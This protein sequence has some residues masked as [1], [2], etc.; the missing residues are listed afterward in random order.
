MSHTPTP[1]ETACPS[2]AVRLQSLCDPGSLPQAVATH[3]AQCPSCQRA[4]ERWAPAL[5][6]LH[7]AEA[8]TPSV[9]LTQRILADLQAQSPKHHTGIA[10]RFIRYYAAAA[11]L[12][13]ACLGVGLHYHSQPTPNAPAT[14]SPQL[15]WLDQ[16]QATD[17]SWHPQAFG[18]KAIY[19][20]ALTGLTLMG[21]ST[22]TPA[23]SH[24]PAREDTL[25]RAT[26][27][28]IDQQLPNGRIGQGTGDA[29]MYNHTMATLGLIQIADQLPPDIQHHARRAATKA[30]AFTQSQQLAHGGWGYFQQPE[31]GANSGVTSWAIQTLIEAD[32]HGYDIATHTI[33]RGAR[34]LDARLRPTG[35]FSY[36]D[37]AETDQP[38]TALTAMGAL[39]LLRSGL[40]LAP[41]RRSQLHAALEAAVPTTRHDMYGTY[42][43][44]AALDAAGTEHCGNL[45][46][47]LKRAINTDPNSAT[48]DRWHNAGGKVYA[49]SLAC[50]TLH[51][52][53]PAP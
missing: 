44:A 40:P 23:T 35:S 13:L 41:Q 2:E 8:A 30:V 39:C 33:A 10:P 18:G 3:V 5:Q 14:T 32:A 34:W 45:L 53:T 47:G 27:F 42:L 52:G 17:G 24:T 51:T 36:R 6:V 43:L 28:L 49:T 31:I 38:S 16:A 1:T 21:Y 4:I 15:A 26:Q 11:A 9:D 46:A 7:S 19:T 22:A 37:T 50:L 20:E 48:Q 29:A 25:S 12:L